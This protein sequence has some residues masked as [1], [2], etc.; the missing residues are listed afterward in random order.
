[1]L[2]LA[3]SHPRCAHTDTKKMSSLF[4]SEN[5][6]PNAV[7]SGGKKSITA[8]TCLCG[9]GMEEAGR[10]SNAPGR[11]Y[12]MVCATPQERARTISQDFCTLILSLP[13]S[14]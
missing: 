3:I 13:R 5:P 1:M 11:G 7:L 4:V 14:Q 9:R 6:L 2:A 8:Y 12:R 10:D